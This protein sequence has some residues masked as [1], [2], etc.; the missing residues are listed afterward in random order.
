MR[1]EH[2]IARANKHKIKRCIVCS[3]WGVAESQKD[4]PFWFRWTIKF[5]NIRFAYEDHERQEDLLKSS[6]LNWIIV[7]PVGLTNGK[8][9]R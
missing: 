3:A 6:D 1:M 2:L 5:S 8:R 7:R 4:I 9:N